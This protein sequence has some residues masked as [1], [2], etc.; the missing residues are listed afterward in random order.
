[1][2]K[3]IARV[4]KIKNEIEL[5]ELKIEECSEYSEA[6]SG[7]F[8]V[9]DYKNIS[10]VKAFLLKDYKTFEDQIQEAFNDFNET[11]DT[12]GLLNILEVYKDGETYTQAILEENGGIETILGKKISIDLDLSQDE[13]EEEMYKEMYEKLKAEH[14]AEIASMNKKVEELENSLKEVNPLK[15]ALSKLDRLE[16]ENVDDIIE[17]LDNVPQDMFKDLLYDLLADNAG[18]LLDDPSYNV[19]ELPELTIYLNQI[20]DWLNNNGFIPME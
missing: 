14:E 6:L 19:D 16:Y 13:E 4:L 7:Y 12:K 1:M 8:V 20:A 17:L 15:E 2:D 9:L 3:S 18:P 11:G 10:D 5:T